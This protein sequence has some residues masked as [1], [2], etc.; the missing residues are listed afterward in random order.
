[1]DRLYSNV[2][3][4]D[5]GKVSSLSYACYRLEKMDEVRTAVDD[6][7]SIFKSFRVNVFMHP[8]TMEDFIE[9]FGSESLTV[10]AYVSH[11]KKQFA[12]YAECQD[13]RRLE[14]MVIRIQPQ[15]K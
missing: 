15:P 13:D 7:F 6:C 8:D 10:N 4:T 11:L 12:V 3:I 14:H 1:M 2:R 5:D 9:F